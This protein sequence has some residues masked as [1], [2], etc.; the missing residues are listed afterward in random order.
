MMRS[1]S[2]GAGVRSSSKAPIIVRPTVS[3]QYFTGTLNPVALSQPLF[4]RKSVLKTYDDL[5]NLTRH[6][7]DKKAECA[8]LGKTLDEK[9]KEP[10]LTA[11]YQF[12]KW[13]M[14]FQQRLK[15]REFELSAFAHHI[16]SFRRD[17]DPTFVE[18]D[19]SRIKRPNFDAITVSLLVSNWQRS[20][21]ST[22]DLENQKKELDQLVEQQKSALVLLKARLALFT[23]FQ[24]DNLSSTVRACLDAHIVPHALAGNAPTRALELKTK[25]KLMIA[26]LAQLVGER[27]ELV[28]LR[29]QKRD[30][31]RRHRLRMKMATKIQA[32]MRGFKVRQKRR[33]MKAAARL[34]QSV[35][36]GYRVRWAQKQ[37]MEQMEGFFNDSPR[38]M[39]KVTKTRVNPDGSEQE[40]YDYQYD[41]PDDNESKRDSPPGSIVAEDAD[42][43]QDMALGDD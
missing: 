4:E 35:W 28:R 14:E 37:V 10:K 2:K 19:A 30:K 5:S 32:V 7:E 9:L 27:R 12:K 11:F 22:R 3:N 39:R 24:R 29:M 31:L 6:L 40:Y 17:P 23:K 38:K 15:N 42:D 20:G 18:V 13:I 21:F 41:D 26:T 1:I 33:Q 36:R 43:M 16:D 8:S 25:R 34:I